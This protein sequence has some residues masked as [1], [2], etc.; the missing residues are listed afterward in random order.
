MKL[1]VDSGSTKME[2]MLLEASGVKTRFIT[3]GFNPFYADNNILLNILSHEMPDD[4]LFD[5][6]REIYYYG[7]GCSTEKN[8][9]NVSDIFQSQFANADIFVSNDMLAAA[10]SVLGTQ[11]GIACILGTGSNSCLYD[12][13]KIVDKAVSLGYLVGDEGSGGSIGREVVRSYFYGFMPKELAEAFE[14]KYHLTRTKFLERLYHNG[15]SS[16]YLGGFS[17]FASD[18]KSD[19]F[20][21]ELCSKCFN[22]FIDAFVRRYP[23]YHKFPVSFVGSVGFHFQDILR[24]CLEIAD[25]KMGKVLCSPAEGLIDYHLAL[26]D[27]H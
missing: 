22:N 5:D 20:I 17:I 2:W 6:I 9:Q 13:H 27:K 10:H 24:N 19:A 1:V 15:Q 8:C 16:K 26:N 25:I 23:N 12:G 7:T 18:H 14:E 3:N 21:Q 11:K 4:M